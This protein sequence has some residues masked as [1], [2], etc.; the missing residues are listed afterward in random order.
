M[1]RRC[2]HLKTAARA[3]YFGPTAGHALRAGGPVDPLSSSPLVL[4]GALI[5]IL[6]GFAALGALIAALIVLS[7]RRLDLELRDRRGRP[8]AGAQVFAVRKRSQVGDPL[9][10]QPPGEVVPRAALVSRFGPP[11]GETDAEGRLTHGKLFRRTFLLVVSLPNDTAAMLPPENL[12]RSGR[13][14]VRFDE[15]AALEVVNGG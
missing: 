4:I 7:A 15:N 2:A 11:L 6:G 8:V 1:T 9:L 5:V 12:G 13:T 10:W 3:G 14:R